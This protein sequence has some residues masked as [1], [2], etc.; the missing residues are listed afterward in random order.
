MAALAGTVAAVEALEELSAVLA[1][2]AGAL[3]VPGA[4]VGV[5]VGDSSFVAVHGVTNVEFPNPITPATQF[6]IGSVTKTFTSA[7][8][9]VLVQEGRLSL[10]DPISRHLPELG[11]ATGLD[12]HS[13][14]LEHA[15]SHQAGFDGDHLFTTSGAHDL[16]ALVGARRLFDPGTGYSYNNAGFS[17]AGAVIEAVSGEDFASFV[18]KRLLKPLGLRGAGFRADD[19]ITY[20]VASPHVVVDAKAF[21]LR[22]AGWQPGWELEPVDHA[23]GGLVASAEHLLTWARF[24]K[25]GTA[26]DGATIL[27]QES[28]ARLHTPVVNADLVEDIAL[29]WFVRD[30]D[31][32]A[33]IGHGGSTAGYLTEFVVV[34]ERD[35]A[36][37]GL[38]NAT[39]GSWLNDA[40]RRWTLA[41][42]A[43][44]DDRA[45][46][47]DPSIAV[48]A[49]RFVGSFVHPFAF[50]T[51][52]EGM[53]PGQLVLTAAPRDDKTGWQPPMDPPR[54]LGFVTDDHAVAIG[55]GPQQLF[56]F[57][58]D[59][60]RPGRVAAIE[61]AAGPSSVI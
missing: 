32:S 47:T 54:T 52:T 33:S 27:S 34:P 8:V 36:F 37:V 1:E 11:P 4:V 29:D 5:A 22:R 9:M 30:I 10:G 31:G 51:V 24:Q 13:T 25:S 6:Q 12:L 35:F 18:R 45:L 40:M 46:E 50:L 58:F 19:V 49:S 56:R 60:G 15:L 41:R 26:A 53:E 14:T 23:A 39:N 17:I 57:G 38:T 2:T 7:A 43:G 16:S 59:A 3:A 21:V 42:F 28:L 55:P 20:P 44:L 61:R 48:D